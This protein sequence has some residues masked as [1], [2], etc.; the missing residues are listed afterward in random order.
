MCLRPIFL[1]VLCLGVATQALGL[2]PPAPSSS[3]VQPQPPAAAATTTPAS[4][5]SASAAPASATVSAAAPSAES[6]KSVSGPKSD[7]TPEQMK[8]LRA[9]GYK[10]Q[11]R[12]GETLFCR[13]E[14]VLGSRLEKRVCGTAADI[15]RSTLNSQELAERIQ[16]KAY[17]KGNGNP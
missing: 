5:T 9:A 8:N 10:P 1:L 7:V 6:Q 15:E 16:T 2:D 17:T 13:N 3:A 11:V 14:P 12:N 4:A